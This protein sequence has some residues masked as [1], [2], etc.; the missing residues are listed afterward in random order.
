MNISTSIILTM[1]R[2]IR[3]WLCF[4]TD[5]L[6]RILKD[7]QTCKFIVKIS[8]GTRI[9]LE[10]SFLGRI[11]K[12]NEG[13]NTDI[14][15]TSSF[16]GQAIKLFSAYKY[17]IMNYSVTSVIRATIDK[18][19]KN[20]Y[21]RPIKTASVIIIVAIITNTAFYFLLK[22]ETGSF[23]WFVKGVLLFVAL[24][25]LYSDTSWEELSKTSYFI[26]ILK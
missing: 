20:L 1:F 26:K 4:I 11:T 5:G 8:E 24:N 3:L 7:S 15:G 19:N 22:N 17:K 21:F 12:I 10:Y 14:L 16:V 6:Y 23:G 25:G 2:K 9:N 13:G 18:L